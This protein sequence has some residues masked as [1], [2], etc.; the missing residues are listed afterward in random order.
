M[1]KIGFLIRGDNKPPN[2][3]L[4]YTPTKLSKIKVKNN[5]MNKN[6]TYDIVLIKISGQFNLNPSVPQTMFSKNS[7]NK[8]VTI[9]KEKCF[10]RELFVLSF[11]E[12]E[13]IKIPRATIMN[14]TNTGPAVLKNKLGYGD[15]VF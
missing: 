6:E 8:R 7:C 4:L 11:L 15:W 2:Y 9:R 3:L 10:F 5:I 1:I 14:M 12:K 13:N